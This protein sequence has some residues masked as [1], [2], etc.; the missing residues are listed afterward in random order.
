MLSILVCISELREQILT[1]VNP[2][3]ALGAADEETGSVC[4]Q[5][6][7]DRLLLT[8]RVFFCGDGETYLWDQGFSS[9]FPS[10]QH[11]GIVHAVGTFILT[12][13]AQRNNDCF[14]NIQ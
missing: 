9:H 11:D 8:L 10:R 5:L 3:V 6:R 1:G 7:C 14:N 13:G 2:N 12:E 4:L